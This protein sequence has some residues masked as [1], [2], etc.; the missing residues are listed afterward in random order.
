MNLRK[1]D[2]LLWGKVG[3]GAKSVCLGISLPEGVKKD[4]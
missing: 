4:A 2:Q 1:R 3:L